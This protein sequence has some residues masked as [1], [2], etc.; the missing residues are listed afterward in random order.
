MSRKIPPTKDPEDESDTNARSLE[1]VSKAQLPTILDAVRTA[2]EKRVAP[3]FHDKEKQ[4]SF[5]KAVAVGLD[6][7]GSRGEAESHLTT[8][9]FKTIKE[10]LD[11]VRAVLNG[12]DP[13][14]RLRVDIAVER[15]FEEMRLR[16]AKGDASP[17][18]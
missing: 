16:T 15:A 17:S 10:K 1:P 8:M 18:S 4:D 14:E 12:L 11:E 2:L 13:F 7:Y 3:V 6:V 9:K 5:L